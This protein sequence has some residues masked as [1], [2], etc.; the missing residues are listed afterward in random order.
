MSLLYFLPSIPDSPLAY[1][2]AAVSSRSHA[3]AFDTATPLTTLTGLSPITRRPSVARFSTSFRGFPRVSNESDSRGETETGRKWKDRCLGNSES[4]DLLDGSRT[5]SFH[6][7]KLAGK[8]R[9][10]GYNARRLSYDRLAFAPAF[11]LTERG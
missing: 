10:S 11:A 4:R 3:I 6:K 5:I 2:F 7:W 9:P 8:W 1:P